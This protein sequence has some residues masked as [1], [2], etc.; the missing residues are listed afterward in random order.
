MDTTNTP[1]SPSSDVAFTPSV[2]RVQARRGSR[3]A[4]AR[5]EAQGGFHTTIT[6]DLAAFIAA[7]NSLYMATASAD[8][9]PYVQHRGG[10]RGFLKV[11]DERTLG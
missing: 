1:S 8:G 2:K 11:L 5:R 7:R 9:Q 10:P 4:Y 3:E 6:A